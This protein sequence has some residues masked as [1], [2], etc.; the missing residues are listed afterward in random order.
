MD[1]L[2][3]RVGGWFVAGCAGS[4]IE[5]PSDKAT[6]FVEAG[7][8][9][10]RRPVPAIPDSGIVDPDFDDSVCCVVGEHHGNGCVRIRVAPSRSKVLFH[11]VLVLSDGFTQYLD[12]RPLTV[13]FRRK[14][15][16]PEGDDSDRHH[17][18]GDGEA[19]AKRRTP[20][21]E[22][23]DGQDCDEPDRENG[24]RQNGHGEQSCH[25]FDSSF[26]ADLADFA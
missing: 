16:L 21:R 26:L 25:H 13:V 24:E 3:E 18:D 20:L 11:D 22:Q 15:R 9:A 7:Q 6:V 23:P 10:I 2:V 8:D 5:Y 12:D 19:S 1:V 14:A 4:E 17:R